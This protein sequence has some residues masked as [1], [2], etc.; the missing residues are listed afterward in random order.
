MVEHSVQHHP[1]APTVGL[2]AQTGEVGVGAQ[3]GVDLV[4]VGGAV[5]VVLRRLEDGVEVDGLYP[6]LL[7]VVQL[8]DDP[9][10]VAAEKVPVAHLAPVVGPP[11]RQ[12]LPALMDPPSAHHAGG[13]GNP[14]A[15]KTVG[16]DLVGHPLPKPGGDLLRAVI[17]GK[18]VGAQLLPSAV[19]SLQ[20]KGVPHQSHIVPGVQPGPEQVRPQLR[21]SPGHGELP[22]LLPGLKLG[23]HP[24]PG[25]AQAAAGPQGQ[26]HPRP[27]GDRPVGAFIAQVTGVVNWLIGHG[28]TLISE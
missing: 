22:G 3:H 11:L 21:A 18:L 6:Q 4:I 8:F 13:V 14:A 10:Q 23:G 12:L 17:D 1:H 2:V 9:P 24:R 15:Q 5:A 27:R 28:I 7:Q 16:K 20:H 19:Q 26:L 25:E